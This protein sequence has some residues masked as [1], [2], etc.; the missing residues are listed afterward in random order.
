M[1]TVGLS[2]DISL[3]RR[4]GI[5]FITRLV[6]SAFATMHYDA[7]REAGTPSVGTISYSLV[8]NNNPVSLGRTSYRT[9]PELRTGFAAYTVIQFFHLPRTDR[10]NADAYL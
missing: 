5:G 1:S 7:K 2:S 3:K 10:D 4:P 8:T 9:V 6:I